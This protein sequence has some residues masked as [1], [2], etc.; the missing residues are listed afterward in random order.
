MDD[1]LLLSRLDAHRL[2]LGTEQI[3]LS[4][5]LHQLG[6]EFAPLAMDKEI[7]FHVQHPDVSILIRGALS[8][9]QVVFRNMIDNALKFTPQ[10]GRVSVNL[11]KEGDFAKVMVV[12][13]GQGIVPEHLPHIGKRFYRTDKARNRQSSGTGLGLALAQSILNLYDGKFEIDSAGIGQGT[14]V[15][16]YWPLLD[17]EAV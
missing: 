8:H 12:D 4:R 14:Q 15:T 7:A 17:E 10:Q 16:V 2:E 13:S 1:L 5:L 6:K 3:D 11:V 9:A